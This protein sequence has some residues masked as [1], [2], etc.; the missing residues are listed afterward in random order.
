MALTSHNVNPQMPGDQYNCMNAAMAHNHYMV[1][2][3]PAY[4][5][6]NP[7]GG[8]GSTYVNNQPQALTSY[9]GHPPAT[10][11]SQPGGASALN[12][13]FGAISGHTSQTTPPMPFHGIVMGFNDPS[14]AGHV[15]NV[16]QLPTSNGPLNMVYDPQQQVGFTPT[17]T[18]G[19]G[20]PTQPGTAPSQ[21]NYAHMM[22]WNATN[23]AQSPPANRVT[24]QNPQLDP[25]WQYRSPSSSGS[26]PSSP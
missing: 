11:A 19:A 13:M 5:Q 9:T 4:A 3:Q 10:F 7:A 15:F 20:Q 2:G 22:V 23:P 18:F 17:H 1:T 12:Q 14:Q 24:P 16:H 8:Y 21:Y 6:P 26:P 25:N